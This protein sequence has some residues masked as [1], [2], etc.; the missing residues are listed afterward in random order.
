L[1]G[2][3]GLVLPDLCRSLGITDFTSVKEQ[4]EPNPDFP[5]LPFPN[6]EESGALDLAVETADR[7]GKTLII[8][9]DPDADRF[10]AAEKVEYVPQYIA[11]LFL[12]G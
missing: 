5:T 2:V 10:A 3:G 9:N 12:G 7:E 1:H 4:L 11:Q 6:P 8:A